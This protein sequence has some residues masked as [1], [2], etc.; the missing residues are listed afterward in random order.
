MSG[1]RH[2]SM[3]EARYEIDLDFRRQ[4]SRDYTKSYLHIR[5]NQL[6]KGEVEMRIFQ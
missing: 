4:Q 6:D 2:I 3:D 1:I 5:R